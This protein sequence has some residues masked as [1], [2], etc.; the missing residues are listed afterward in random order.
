M[1]SFS[2]TRVVPYSAD[3]MFALVA[4]VERYPEFA[5]LCKALTVTRRYAEGDKD[6]ILARMTI[7]YKMI[8]E[9]F[10]SRVRLDPANRL[11]DVDY[12][13]GPFRKL[14]NRWGFTPLQD[15]KACE[16]AFSLDYEFRS[17]SFQLLMGA[18]FDRAF[19]K[20]ATAFE[21]RARVLYGQPARRE[22]AVSSG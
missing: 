9:S 4:D 1:P 7:A 16:V 18:V 3:D 17:R 10:T 5:P 2:T 21:E 12:L 22:T 15:G 19:R 20:F 13:D 6:V 11:I 14:E 8:Q